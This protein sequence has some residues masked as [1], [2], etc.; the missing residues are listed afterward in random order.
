MTKYNLKQIYNIYAKIVQA[1][2]VYQP[3]KAK[4]IIAMPFDWLEVQNLLE[5][6]LK[7]HGADFYALSK[8]YISES[9]EDD[10]LP[11]VQPDVPN[12]NVG[13]IDRYG[14]IGIETLL[15][16]CENSKDHAVTPNDF[17]RMNRVQMLK[18]C[19]DAVSRADVID[20]YKRGA[21]IIAKAKGISVE[22]LPHNG[23][24]ELMNL[25]PKYCPNCGAAMR[26]DQ[27][28]VDQ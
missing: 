8:E 21:E 25:P 12:T 18:P 2:F 1:H 28:E 22:D 9:V 11:S 4:A 26:G 16:F 5:D 20:L 13:K 17:M 24:D 3:S 7:K 27:D 6:Y 23:L 19:E 14:Y 15:N 10:Y